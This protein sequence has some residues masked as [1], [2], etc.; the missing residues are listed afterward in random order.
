MAEL[1][2]SDKPEAREA[3]DLFTYRV[4]REIG[5]LSAALEG[6]QQLVFTGGV[7]EN[8]AAIRSRAC[9]LCAWLGLE[10]DEAAN[11]ENAA[12]IS[13]ERSRV[14]AWVVPTNEEIV[15]ARQARDLLH[16]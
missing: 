15:I 5:S 8:A 2:A 13:T 14:A 9:G 16:A 1:L 6:I 12:R 3:V 11:A 7:G 4:A 10:L